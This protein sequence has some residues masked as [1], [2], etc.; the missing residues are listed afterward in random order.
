MDVVKP[1]FSAPIRDCLPTSIMA[2]QQALNFHIQ[3]EGFDNI[4]FFKS[5]VLY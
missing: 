1:L 2:E 4:L 3:A 5:T